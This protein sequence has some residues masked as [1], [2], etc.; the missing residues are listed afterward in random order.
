[1]E[2]AREDSLTS[3]VGTASGFAS[4]AAFGL[5]YSTLAAGP[6]SVLSPIT[7]LVSA[8]LPAAVGLLTGERLSSLAVAGMLVA[9]IAVIVVGSGPDAHGTRPSPRALVLEPQAGTARRD[10]HRVG[11]AGAAPENTNTGRSV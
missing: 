4:A 9:L 1:M 5:L 3:S 6:M 2:N 7:A 11:T 10:A 8:A